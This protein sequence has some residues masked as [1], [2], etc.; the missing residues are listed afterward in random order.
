MRPLTYAWIQPS[1][2]DSYQLAA[3]LVSVGGGAERVELTGAELDGGGTFD[4]VLVV[5]TFLGVA[6]APCSSTV[7][8]A[9]LPVPAISVQAPPLLVFP[10]SATVTLEARAA[11]AACFMAANTSSSSSRNAAVGLRDHVVARA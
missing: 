7:T 8:R 9:A 6:S 5:T 4:L 10:R 11:I 2:H 3:K 1:D